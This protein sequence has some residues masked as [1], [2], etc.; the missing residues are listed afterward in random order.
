MATEV[1]ELSREVDGVHHRREETADALARGNVASLASPRGSEGSVGHA[2]GNVDLEAE[3]EEGVPA[4]AVAVV[5][6]MQQ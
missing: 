4:D 5:A 2:H 3:A 1:R 6:V